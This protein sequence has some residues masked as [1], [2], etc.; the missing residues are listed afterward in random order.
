MPKNEWVHIH[1][2]GS[3]HIG[4]NPNHL[5]IKQQSVVT[6]IKDTTWVITEREGEELRGEMF[7]AYWPPS[8]HSHTYCLQLQQVCE[9]GGFGPHLP[10]GKQPQ[11]GPG[12]TAS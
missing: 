4:Q 2:S 11:K 5:P 3:L 8:R 6:L 7:I 1:A 10:I 9:A 12:H